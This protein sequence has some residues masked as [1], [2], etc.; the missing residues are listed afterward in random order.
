ML[1]PKKTK[2]KKL[3]KIRIK[4]KNNNIRYLDIIKVK[5][6]QILALQN[7]RLRDD[8]LNAVKL[9]IMKHLK[10]KNSKVVSNVF[11]DLNCTKKASDVRMGKGK[12]FT[13][14]WC[15]K[16]HKG[17]AVFCIFGECNLQLIQ[18]VC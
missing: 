1:L 9:S 14:F 6:V 11:T 2:F 13:N 18:D 12:G 4:R 16:I 8:Q 5:H 7:M 17:V 15:C 10:R 3:Q